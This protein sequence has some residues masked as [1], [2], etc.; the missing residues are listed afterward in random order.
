MDT[1]RAAGPVFRLNDRIIT[2]NGEVGTVVGLYASIDGPTVD[3]EIVKSRGSYSPDKL[4]LADPRAIGAAKGLAEDLARAHAAL[5][6]AT[7]AAAE[8]RKAGA[9]KTKAA[10]K[11][12]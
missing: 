5:K 10:K 9:T 8:A 1:N 2:P 4:E 7:V 6:A 12:R 11:R 3:V